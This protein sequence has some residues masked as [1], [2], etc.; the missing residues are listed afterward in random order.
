VDRTLA[1][2]S[3]AYAELV[4]RYRRAAFA[5]ALAVVS[6]QQEADDV[7]QDSF[8]QGY[9]QLGSCRDP[10]RFGAWLLTIVRR[11]ALNQLR[12]IKRRRTVSLEPTVAATSPGTGPSEAVET[13]EL[14]STL[15]AALA[16]LS[17]VQREVVLL[18]DL[19]DW[20]HADIADKTGISV[21]MSRR[22]LSDARRKLRGLLA[23][24]R[25]GRGD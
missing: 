17:P 9:D 7:A 3:T 21:T 25:R 12:S 11:R 23:S 8:I 10:S 22:H 18:A 4:R 2:D 5:C 15:L 19:E 13:A 24:L 16:Q 1:G 20:S 6:D 14:R